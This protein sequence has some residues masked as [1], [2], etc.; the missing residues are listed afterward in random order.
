[1]APSSLET[2]ISKRSARKVAA[3][4]LLGLIS[5]MGLAACSAGD[6]DPASQPK[7]DPLGAG[8]RIRQVVNPALHKAD[9]DVFV[10][11][12]EVI[13]VDTFDETGDGKS[14][15]TIYVQDVGSQDAYSGTSLYAPAFVPANL[16]VSPGDV[17]DLRGPYT[18]MKAIGSAV[19]DEGQVLPQISKPTATFRYETQLPPP[20][21]I[22][23]TDLNE[24]GK[25]RQWMNMLVTVKDVTLAD[26]LTGD[27]KNTG[28][29][30]AH[31]SPG[32]GRDSVTMSNEFYDLKAGSI[33]AGTKLKS[34]TGVVTWFFS[35]HIAPRS[36]ADIEM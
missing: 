17:L 29:V 32:A 25:G 1:M 2:Q 22:D 31:I 15:G 35:Y 7:P 16:K 4:G 19:F 13:A 5:F 34:L 8:D 14:R 11:G 9:A 20:V 10:T 30:T 27:A 12:A 23:V 18:E 6:G 3:I 36:Q 28:R 33:P 26:D 24:Y 21:E